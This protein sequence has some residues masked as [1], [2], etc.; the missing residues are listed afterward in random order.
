[1]GK[2]VTYNDYLR[3]NSIIGKSIIENSNLTLKEADIENL[4]SAREIKERFRR[5]H[6]FL[7]L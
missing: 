5:K 1:M 3:F 4:L 2:K 7:P 6:Y